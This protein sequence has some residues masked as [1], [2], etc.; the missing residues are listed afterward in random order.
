M[1]VASPL[2]FK[3]WLGNRI[4]IPALVSIFMGLYVIIKIWETIFCL[5][6]NGVG[7]IKLQLYMSVGAALLNIPLSI[8]F[9][10]TLGLGSAGVIMATCVCTL[11]ALF[12][13]PIQYKKIITKTDYGIWGK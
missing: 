10:T 6:I 4:Q 12:L 11:Y 3:L 7:K 13:W 1:I 8:Y 9:A 2:V 5:F